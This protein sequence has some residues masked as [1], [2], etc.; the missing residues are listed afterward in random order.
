MKTGAIVVAVILTMFSA[1]VGHSADVVLARDGKALVNI[2]KPIEPVPA[3]TRAVRELQDYLGKITGATFDAI[4]EKD[5]GTAPAIYV[6]P[7]IFA[8]AKGIDTTKLGS[9]ES[10]IR[11]VGN[12]MIITGGRPRGTL[13]GVYRFLEGQ[14]G[15]RWYTPEIEKVPAQKTCLVKPCDLKQQPDFNMR[16]AYGW[17]ATGW[18]LQRNRINGPWCGEGYWYGSKY[19]EKPQAPETGGGWVM[20][21]PNGHT[22]W[23]YFPPS[24]YFDAHPEYYTMR[25]GVRV[26]HT[27]QQYGVSSD[28]LCLTNPE[29]Q[30]LF[31]DKILEM[32]QKIP[33]GNVAG[34]GIN[35]GGCQTV[36]DC[37]ACSAY[38][39][40][41]GNG[42]DLL[43]SFI[44]PIA[45][46]VKK[47]YPDKYITSLVSYGPT[48]YGPLKTSI[49][50]NVIPHIGTIPLADMVTFPE[51]EKTFWYTE[52]ASWC[53]AAKQVWVWEKYNNAF[54]SFG[55]LRPQWWQ[56][57]ENM[58]MLR[59]LG[60]TGNFTEDEF[61]SQCSV[62][63]EFF[64]MRSWIH[65]RMAEDTTLNVD[66]L[67]RDYLNGVYGAGGPMLFDYLML[68]KARR[69]LWP[70]R[71][72]NFEYIDKSQKLFEKAEAAVAKDPTLRARVKEARI[73]L[74]V[75]T[76]AWRN[77]AIRDYLQ[78]G[79][80]LENYPYPKEKIRARAISELEGTVCPLW[81][82]EGT[83]WVWLEYRKD[84][85]YKYAQQYVEALAKGPEYTPLPEELQK[86]PAE[87]VIEIPLGVLDGMYTSLVKDQ[88]ASLG[89]A[90]L[91]P[92]KTL[93][94]R[95]CASTAEGVPSTAIVD[96]TT[97]KG[98]G[99]RLYKG[100]R[101]FSM[102]DMSVPAKMPNIYTSGVGA[103]GVQLHSMYDPA[104]PSR[105]WE[106]Y[107]TLKV[108]GL[109]E[110]SGPTAI[111]FDRYFLVDVDA[112]A[113]AEAARVQAAQEAK[114]APAVDFSK[115]TADQSKYLLG[116]WPFDD[117]AGLTAA[118][119]SGKG[120]IGAI[121]G[122]TWT[123]GKLGKAL[124][125]AG[126]NATP[127][128]VRIPYAPAL[129]LGEKSFTIAL[130][131]KT[132]NTKYGQGIL[133]QWSDKT[134]CFMIRVQDKATLALVTYDSQGN[135]TR[136]YFS[137][138][139]T[140]NPTDGNWHHLVFGYDRQ[141][142]LLYGYLDGYRYDIVPLD[143]FPV[144]TGALQVGYSGTGYFDG[145]IDDVRLYSASVTALFQPKSGVSPR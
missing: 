4:D 13:Y 137:K 141:K 50:D 89:L 8:K 84:P 14:L 73:Q 33:S 78:T 85:M 56:I 140:I 132:E 62:L 10:I 107:V 108:D 32:F 67:M 41:H 92:S 61:A 131:Y 38:V 135:D 83:K 93:P 3:E 142:K 101:R 122:A 68:Q 98:P 44:T 115:P 130:W 58:R 46:A 128:V 106:F 59:K 64:E 143:A 54:Y 74:D 25:N 118:D 21:G 103:P 39:K 113:K 75:T 19:Y 30:S 114:K 57:E 49:P 23:Y 5:A 29:V 77:K 11:T 72:V 52:M 86:Y 47:A 16:D 63:G 91:C 112:E 109:T 27:D 136:L 28:H 2:I 119:A 9:E 15:V 139:D 40:E 129:N 82:K 94:L 121:T 18:W 70:W 145:A 65:A 66:D 53:K 1:L 116:A 76:L 90:Y 111:Y 51:V 60:V 12:S 31:K 123:D 48:H 34:I 20:A 120:N 117:G 7:T 79:G 125:F 6:G 87:T 24:K 35:D 138:T 88:D 124:L 105:K 97:V 133:Q 22:F 80:K 26:K 17:G 96:R 110:T 37:P 42:S 104:N 95:P 100:D 134:H 71:F 69:P 36:C 102:G 55:Y 127:Q 126:S 43:M 99:Y 81:R 144:S 45:D